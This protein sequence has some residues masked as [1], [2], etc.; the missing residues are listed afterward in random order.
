M[1][2]LYFVPYSDT[3]NAPAIQSISALPCAEQMAYLDEPAFGMPE[4]RPCPGPKG[5][6][7]LLMAFQS[8]KPTHVEYVPEKQKWIE[9]RAKGPEIKDEDGNVTGREPGKT[10][11]WIGW[12]IG[13]LPGPEDLAKKNQ[14]DGHE[15]KLNDGN[16][17]L[18]PIVGPVLSR[19]PHE[20]QVKDGGEVESVVLERYSNIW[21]RSKE[22]YGFVF[23]KHSIFRERS[24]EYLADV[25]S[26]NYR[27]GRYEA[28]AAVLNLITTENFR[29]AVFVSVGKREIEAAEEATKKNAAPQ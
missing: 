24:F 3:W 23:M 22:F 2:F 13:E 26:L 25:L 29:E 27:I 20:F 18:I 5:D 9:V 16:D 17:W 10:Q 15:V 14:F 12:W 4:C 28:S 1:S 7:G 21:A 19:L 6:H 11:Y 8:G